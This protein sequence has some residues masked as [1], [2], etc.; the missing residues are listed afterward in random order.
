MIPQ[1]ELL[2]AGSDNCAVRV[3]LVHINIG[4]IDGMIS[5]VISEVYPHRN[6][7]AQERRLSSSLDTNS[8]VDTASVAIINWYGHSHVT[9][10][11]GIV[12]AAVAAVILRE[13]VL[14]RRVGGED[15]VAISVRIGLA[16]SRQLW[17][18]RYE[19]T[20]GWLVVPCEQV[21]QAGDVGVSAS[22]PK[23]GGRCQPARGCRIAPNVVGGG[24][25]QAA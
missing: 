12:R 7:C 25:G 2:A 10:S 24:G 13:P 21:D 9:P 3:I 4:G 1:P 11:E 17:I 5:I 22:E 23:G 8:L 6:V 20:G 16:G 14:P 18:D 19:L 15:W